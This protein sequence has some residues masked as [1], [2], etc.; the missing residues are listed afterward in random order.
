LTHEQYFDENYLSLFY[1]LKV[2]VCL[3]PFC[4]VKKIDKTLS[5]RLFGM[6]LL[7]DILIIF[8]GVMLASFKAIKGYNFTTLMLIVAFE[9]TASIFTVFYT[10][11]PPKS[12]KKRYY[13]I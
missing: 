11:K 2:I 10:T 3:V 8:S 9:L 4:Y 6:R 1:A 12:D 5:P 13:I 7:L